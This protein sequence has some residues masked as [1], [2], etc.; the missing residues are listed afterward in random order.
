M[1]T[2]FPLLGSCWR[3]R[4]V[5]EAPVWSTRRGKR[6]RLHGRASQR[7]GGT[8]SSRKRSGGS[9]ASTEQ[10]AGMPA[11]LPP[12]DRQAEGR[13][14]GTSAAPVDSATGNLTPNQAE[15]PA[16]PIPEDS[17][18]GSLTPYQTPAA[19]PA[20]TTPADSPEA[21]VTPYQTPATTPAPADTPGY[22]LSPTPQ[23]PYR[24]PTFSDSPAEAARASPSPRPTP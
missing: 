24:S 23:R 5:L 1:G 8:T 13:A 16:S 4:P 20:P 11:L 2:G 14:P 7:M 22:S 15:T 21:G 9:R 18:A 19:T 3:R 6:R 10:P 12:T 17:P